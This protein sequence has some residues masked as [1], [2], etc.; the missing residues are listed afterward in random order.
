MTRT[1]LAEGAALE[2]VAPSPGPQT[3]RDPG[4]TGRGLR[5]GGWE[6]GLSPELCGPG[7]QGGSGRPCR[8]QLWSP[9]A[10]PLLTCTKS[11]KFMDN[12]QGLL[13]SPFSLFTNNGEC[14]VKLDFV[15]CRQVDRDVVLR[16]RP[17]VY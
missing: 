16:Y 1:S 5:G 3:P 15:L 7:F 2:D 4:L 14:R 11:T 10:D 13:R 8:N 12:C 17:I 6:K 9:A